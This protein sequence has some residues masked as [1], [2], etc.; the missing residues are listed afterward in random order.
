MSLRKL[1]LRSGTPGFL[2][3]LGLSFFL[4]FLVL[5][6]C[7]NV[8]FLGKLGELPVGL[9]FLVQRL[10]EQRRGFAFAQQF[11]PGSD[12]A[13][14]RDLIVLDTL[15]SRDESR[16]HHFALEI[17]VHDF[18]AFL[19]EALHACAFLAG[20][21]FVKSVKNFF[22]ALDVP[23]GLFEMGLEAGAEIV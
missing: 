19:Y 17:L 7:L 4:T 21:L 8:D 22:E 14:R 15:S 16:V 18:F 13:I 12:A 11:G 9:L 3:G 2:A 1:A 10:L 20:G 23:L 6:F 5:T